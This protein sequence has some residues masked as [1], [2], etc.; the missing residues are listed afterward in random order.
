M[1]KQ[2]ASIAANPK[3]WRE[4]MEQAKSKMKSILKERSNSN[5]ASNSAIKSYTKEADY[6]SPKYSGKRAEEKRALEISHPTRK[7]K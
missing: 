7:R 6:K 4:N 5:V 2:I 1:K 3:L